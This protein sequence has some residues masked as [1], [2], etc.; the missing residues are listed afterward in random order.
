MN[1]V[2]VFNEKKIKVNSLLESSK[3][4]SSI[5]LQEFSL[6]IVCSEIAKG[7]VDLLIKSI[8]NPGHNNEKTPIILLMNKVDLEMIKL[9]KKRVDKVLSGEATPEELFFNLTKLVPKVIKK[10]K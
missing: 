5:K 8:K 2:G 4:I 10:K 9:N 1:I 6:I 3:A 7:N